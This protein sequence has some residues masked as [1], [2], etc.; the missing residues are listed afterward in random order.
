MKN[1]KGRGGIDNINP[2]CMLVGIDVGKHRQ[3]VYMSDSFNERDRKP[4]YINND[5][6][7]YQRLIG[8]AEKQKQVWKLNRIIFGLE[9]TGSYGTPL[10]HYLTNCGYQ[11]KTINP[12]H[13]KRMKD[14]EDNA[15][16][17]SDQ[18]DPKIIVTLMRLDKSISH[19]IPDGIYAELR[20]LSKYYQ[21]L[22]EQ[23]NRL[24]NYVE[25]YYAEYF[26][27]LTR[28]ASLNSKTLL[29][30]LE[31]FPLPGDI[32]QLD[33]AG[34]YSIMKEKSR[35]SLRPVKLE[36][37]YASS[38]T[39][40]GIVK[41]TDSAREILR[42]LGA[43]IRLKLEQ[44]K[45]TDGKIRECVDR[46]PYGELLCSIPGLSKLSVGLLLSEIGDIRQ[47]NH[48]RE[49][50]KLSGLNLTNYQSGRYMGRYHISKVGRPRLRNLLYLLCIEMI[51]NNPI[52]SQ[53]YWY[54]VNERNSNK[55]KTILGMCRKLLE[56]MY[57]MVKYDVEYDVER[58]KYYAGA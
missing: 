42:S 51:T 57:S 37:I 8:E 31:S 22:T 39:S 13:T 23:L 6:S 21:S 40:I 38:A 3:W 12:M 4:F 9:P 25:S 58:R 43:D 2:E 7:G 35:H 55:V 17:K 26:P 18:K 47:Y 20:N 27:E 32:S 30:T 5:L 1:I 41:G 10:L 15:P 50:I 11:V 48:A 44:K 45:E 52:L 33:Y 14:V 53:V 29:Y 19:K 56:M 36:S 34:Y 46:I 49:L 54:Q 24:Y 16:G 28:Y